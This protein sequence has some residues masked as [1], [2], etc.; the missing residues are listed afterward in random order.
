LSYLPFPKEPVLAKQATESA[1]YLK[2]SAG[3][4]SDRL[5]K[6]HCKSIPYLE[7]PMARL[8]AIFNQKGI[9]TEA[10]LPLKARKLALEKLFKVTIQQ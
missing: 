2:I 1:R 9:K 3:V 6:L 7:S 5:V 8:C 4:Q 10:T